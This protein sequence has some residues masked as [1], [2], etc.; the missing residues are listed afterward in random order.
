[1]TEAERVV[2]HPVRRGP[3]RNWVRPLL[4][5]IAVVLICIF[6]LFPFYWL[7]NVSLKTG[8]DLSQSDIFPPNPTLDNYDSIFKNDNFT[9]A[10]KNSVIVT[11]VTTILALIVGS[12]A[13]YALARL[14]FKRKF[15]ILALILSIS[16]FPAIAIAA[17]IFKL[18]TDIGLYDTRIGLIFP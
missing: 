15:L 17:P 13:A 14:R 7:I 11:T 2:G 5:T 3:R 16:T 10:L 4:M 12:F 18:W 9:S 1:M 6:C 8:S